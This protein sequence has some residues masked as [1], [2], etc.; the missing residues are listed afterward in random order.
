MMESLLQKAHRVRLA[1]QKAKKGA[2]ARQGRIKAVPLGARL[3]KHWKASAELGKQ[4]AL[5]IREARK[6]KHRYLAAVY[7]LYVQARQ[8]KKLEALWRRAQPGTKPVPSMPKHFIAGVIRGTY[9]DK[10]LER[11]SVGQWAEA[12]CGADVKKCPPAKAYAFFAEGGGIAGAREVYHEH[13]RK[14]LPPEAA[15]KD[16]SGSDPGPRKPDAH[17]SPAGRKQKGTATSRSGSPPA[18]NAAEAPTA[19][20][21]WIR[22][23]F[24]G[25]A[26]R[27]ATEIRKKGR[28][29][30]FNYE[31]GYEPETGFY[32]H[33][34]SPKL[35]LVSTS[36][37]SATPPARKA[38]LAGLMA[39]GRKPAAAAPKHRREHRR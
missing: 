15:A 2:T 26:V 38:K 1:R 14:Q 28:A 27:Q 3:E 6:D 32:A 23:W 35:Q 36:E 11:D 4:L 25:A 29:R 31:G 5:R 19:D 33:S 37:P 30:P 34:I 13:T 22:V 24:T 8:A 20:R 39:R 21:L 9:A 12:V 16:S 10:D 7:H 17:A 18:A